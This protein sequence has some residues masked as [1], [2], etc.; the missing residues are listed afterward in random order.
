M[1]KLLVIIILIS[2]AAAAQIQE[3]IKT[4]SRADVD[5]IVNLVLNETTKKYTQVKVDSVKSRYYI[6]NQFSDGE[7]LV[8][9]YFAKYNEGGNKDLNITGSNY[10]RFARVAG[11]YK[12][13]FPFWKKYFQPDADFLQVATNKNGKVVQL[14]SNGDNYSAAFNKAGD[15]WII[16]IRKY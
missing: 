7:N 4:T 16:E 13:V 5:L 3:K 11:V 8:N 15:A 10:Y 14:Q 12:D 2:N 9:V 1:K 6:D